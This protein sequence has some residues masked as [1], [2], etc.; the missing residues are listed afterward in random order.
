MKGIKKSNKRKLNKVFMW[1]LSGL[2]LITGSLYG[3]NSY[4]NVRADENPPVPSREKKLINNNDGTY[5]LSLDVVG[6]A[7]K[8]VNK[9]NVI[10][11]LD[12]SGSMD[13][14]TNASGY[15][16]SNSNG[17]NM[18]GMVNSEF[19]PLTRHSSGWGPWTSYSYTVTSTGANYTGTRYLYQNGDV[20]RLGAA[21]AAVI[22]LARGLLSNNTEQNNDLVELALVTF[23]NG[24]TVAQNPTTSLNDFTNSLSRSNADG[25]T[26]WEAGLQAA[27][28]IDFEDGANAKDV[29]YVIFV[30][31]G[32]PTFYATDAGNGDWNGQYGAYGSGYEQ[33]PNVTY[34][35]DAAKDDARAKA[36][37][38]TKQKAKA[39]Q[40]GRAHV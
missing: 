32:N 19:V 27:A 17:T 12:T 9:A 38:K 4:I 14:E 26:N 3:I 18:Y 28:G 39:K 25:G 21:E 8:A 5:T 29:T 2:F 36:K 15:E 23:S 13:E 40:I 1:I 33:E 24:A 35:Y 22:S 34:S 30:S 11:I 37:Q 20:N 31:D 7:D 10:V 16:P 6:D